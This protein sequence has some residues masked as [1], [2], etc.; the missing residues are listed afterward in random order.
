TT[1]GSTLERSRVPEGAFNPF[2]GTVDILINPDGTV[3]PTTIYSSSSSF[4]MAGAFFHLWLAERGD[5]YLPL[6][7]PPPV[8]PAP[9]LPVTQ[10]VT[11]AALSAWATANKGAALY[12]GGAVLKGE[13]RLVT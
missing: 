1:W 2:T 7:L 4:G 13:F 8:P 5:L 3:V 11:P 9:T 10:D 6:P 12:P